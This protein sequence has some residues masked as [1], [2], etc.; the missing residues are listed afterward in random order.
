MTKKSN[1]AGL[2]SFIN[3]IRTDGFDSNH[4]NLYD[5]YLGYIRAKQPRGSH[6]HY[7]STEKESME[8]SMRRTTLPAKEKKARLVTLQKTYTA[9]ADNF[10]FMPHKVFSQKPAISNSHINSLLISTLRTTKLGT[11]QKQLNADLPNTGFADEARKQKRPN[12]AGEHPL[13]NMA[14]RIKRGAPAQELALARKLD[15]SRGGSLEREGPHHDFSASKQR[16]NTASSVI[17]P[18]QVISVQMH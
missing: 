6:Q 8:G 7:S 17:E 15:S 5:E 13:R 18:D 14:L 10:P 12:E 2:S 3:V 16:E 4:S 11:S 1:E 9:G